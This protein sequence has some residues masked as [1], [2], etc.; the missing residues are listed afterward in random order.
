MI[1]VKEV[2]T[3]SNFMLELLFTN[4]EKKIFDM[5]PYLEKGIF[6]NLKDVSIFNS[7]FVSF[8]T[9]EWKNGIDICPDLLYENSYIK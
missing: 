3:L 1:R 6:K 2:E 7:A 4:G 5:N 9:V 8:G